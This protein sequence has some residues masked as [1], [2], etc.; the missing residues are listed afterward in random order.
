MPDCERCR[1]GASDHVAGN[2]VCCYY[3]SKDCDFEE[4]EEEIC[5]ICNGNGEFTGPG[6]GGME[7]IECNRCNGTGKRL[8][9]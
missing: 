1:Y 6:A 5:L 8:P 9:C 7:L 2:I 4:E 3:G